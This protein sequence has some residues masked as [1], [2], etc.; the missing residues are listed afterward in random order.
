[1]LKV[2]NVDT[3]RTGSQAKRGP[4]ANFAVAKE[5]PP[6]LSV[7]RCSSIVSDWMTN[8]RQNHEAC[9]TLS[10]ETKELPY[11]LLDLLEREG[12]S[13]VLVE[14]RHS[15]ACQNHQYATLSH[16]WGKT[17]VVQT[18][19]ENLSERMQGIEWDDL[20]RTFQDAITIIRSLDIRFIWIDSLCIVQDDILDWNKE[21]VRMAAIYANSS[22]N[23]AATGASDS[24]GGCLSPRSLKHVVPRCEIR[25]F[26]IKTHMDPSEPVIFVRPSLESVHHRYSTN[27]SY[28]TDLPDSTT[29][30]LLSRAW[31]F[32]ERYLAPRTLHFHPSEMVMECKSSICCECSGLDKVVAI[33]RRNSLDS[34]LDR[35]KIFNSWFAVVEEYSRLRITRESDRLPALTGVATVFQK[36]LECRYL[37][38]LWENDIARGLLWDVTRYECTRSQRNVRRHR[39]APTWSWASL[40]MDTEGPGIIFSA[41]HDETFEV[42]DRFVFLDTDILFSA[43]DFNVSPTTGSIS[44]RGMSMEATLDPYSELRSPL[45]DVSLICDQDSEDFV[46][47]T[48]TEMN[49]DCTWESP[50]SCPFEPGTTVHCVLVG[51][52][53]DNDWES[54][55]RTPYQCTVVLKQSVSN[56]QMFER[57]GVLSIEEDFG[58]FS[59]APESLFEVI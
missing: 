18:T 4:F 37:A 14:T 26:P 21:S 40:L 57:I 55:Q 25:S 53:V 51:K 42:D 7:E 17:H 28:I 15:T 12:T 54:G 38:G 43:T 32:Q 3:D 31:V 5:L 52:K 45:K 39:Y 34:K 20:P 23:I 36:K 56:A 9:T 58:L 2:I 41:G 48:I 19:K 6:E 8:C 46:L 47:I 30:P 10:S 49:I 11:R 35:S 13:V 59:I 22:I 50:T 29:V 24:R 44:I 16:C 33:S 27:S 1:M